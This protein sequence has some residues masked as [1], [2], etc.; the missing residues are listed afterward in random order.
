M[1]EFDIPGGSIIEIRHIL[2]DY[3]GTLAVDG[4]PISGVKE[5]INALKDEFVFHVITAD[6]FGSVKGALKD[7]ACE[8]VTIPSGNQAQA[9]ADYLKTLGPEFT[10]TCGNGVNDELMLGQAVLGVAVL[11]E[12]GLAVG[13][14]TAADILIK[15]ILDLFGFLEN[16]GRLIA[17]LRR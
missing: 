15:D 13:T 11:Q 5:K 17:C 3:N 2:L 8:V 1:K 12:E 14:L 16:P 9:K 10:L 7:T 4:Q 6:T